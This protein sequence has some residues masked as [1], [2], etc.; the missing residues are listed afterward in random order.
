MAERFC[1]GRICQEVQ[2]PSSAAEELR[3][4]FTLLVCSMDGVLHREYVA[5]QKR[6]ACRLASK[7]QK[8]FSAVTAWVRIHMQFA[9]FRSVDLRLRGT[10]R[11]IWGLGLK[12]GAAIRVGHY[13]RAALSWA[14]TI[15]YHRVG[16]LY[17]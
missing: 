11:R 3:G 12:D 16:R 4:S 5:Y 9:I 8:P 7:W 2:V 6:L 15:Y 1:T 17:K 14:K 13:S 10:R